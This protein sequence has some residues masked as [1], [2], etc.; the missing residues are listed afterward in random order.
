MHHMNYISLVL[1]LLAISG[2]SV[3]Q[4][5]PDAQAM[6]QETAALGKVIARVNGVPIYEALVN[7]DMESNLAKYRKY[8]MQEKDPNLVQRLQKRALDKLIGDELIRQQS[9]KLSIPDMDARVQQKLTALEERHGPGEGMERYL[10]MRHLT[11][12]TLG[13]SLKTRIRVD[14][15]LKQQGV[16]EPMIEE[17]R[18]RQAYENNSKG[19]LRQESIKVSHILIAVQEN[20]GSE[21]RDQARHKAE[22][23]RREILSGQDFAD[24]ARTHSACNSAPGGGNLKYIKRSY[25]PEAFDKVAFAIKKDLLSDVVETRFGYHIIKV[26]DKIPAGRIPYEEVRDFIMKFLQERE[27]KKK[28]NEHIAQL[29]SRAKLELFLAK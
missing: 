2:H 6:D 19:Y 8:G 9:G 17:A 20:A 5:P 23:I 18:I 12:E 15:Y 24:M 11:M 10:K 14:A 25:M 26:V 16:L 27:S 22:Y 3:G 29:K 28:L 21:A 7:P 1:C 13:T 4:I